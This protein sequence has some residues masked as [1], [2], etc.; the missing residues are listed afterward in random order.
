LI[1]GRKAGCHRKHAARSI[2]TGIIGNRMGRLNNLDLLASYTMSIA[3]QDQSG[4]RL[5]SILLPGFLERMRH[6]R[7]G[8]ASPDNHASA[9]RLPR[10]YLRK[11]PHGIGGKQGLLKTLKQSLTRGKLHGKSSG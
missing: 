7:R 2:K 10:S 9:L 6:M 5:Q 8:F 4:E 11:G 1:T 3:C